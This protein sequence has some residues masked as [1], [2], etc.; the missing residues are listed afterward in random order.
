MR[1]NIDGP[2]EMLAGRER[3]I[4]PNSFAFF[5][6]CRKPLGN[7]AGDVSGVYQGK[8]GRRLAID[9]GEVVMHG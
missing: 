2:F 9:N 3:Q 8:P 1:R 4:D 5:V 7:R 6:L